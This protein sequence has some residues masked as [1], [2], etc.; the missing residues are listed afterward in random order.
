M[1]LFLLKAK[2]AKTQ[3][4]AQATLGAQWGPMHSQYNSK[5]QNA[6]SAGPMA[7]NWCRL[8]G[9]G[10]LARPGRLWLRR[11][12]GETHVGVPL[13][14][15]SALAQLPAWRARES[16]AEAELSQRMVAAAAQVVT[17]TRAGG[18]LWNKYRERI[19]RQ[20][21]VRPSACKVSPAGK[22]RV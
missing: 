18:P 15:T 6:E 10:P 4:K 16:G 9:A 11:R 22:R 7:A 1:A 14:S 17:E 5:W 12:R 20:V 3:A 21:L 19:L 2:K 8:N 13:G